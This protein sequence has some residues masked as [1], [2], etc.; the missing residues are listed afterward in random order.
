MA[1]DY[2]FTAG[3][4]C[5]GAP[6]GL[7]AAPGMRCRRPQRYR[8][9]VYGIQPELMDVALG[10]PPADRLSLNDYADHLVTSLYEAYCDARKHLG[11]VAERTKRYYDCKSHPLA[12]KPGDLVYVFS[13]CRFLGR[14]PKWQQ[15]YSGPY[16]VVS[17]VNAVNYGV[18]KGP[19]GAVQIVHVDKLK[20]FLQPGL[21][22]VAAC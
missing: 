17:Q 16:E 10:N 22:D 3:E 14:S 9:R 7:A 11:R 5:R 21:G 15:K 18:R 19:R 20:P 2:E 6:N 1:F 13:P 8:P 4:N 12:F